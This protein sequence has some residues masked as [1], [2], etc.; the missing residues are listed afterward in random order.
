MMGASSHQGKDLFNRMWSSCK[1]IIR[2]G[3]RDGKQEVSFRKQPLI[4]WIQVQQE[5]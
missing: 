4:K 2:A 3:F 1:V 5:K